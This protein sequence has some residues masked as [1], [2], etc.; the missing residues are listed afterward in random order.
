MLVAL[1]VF[2]LLLVSIPTLLC[3]SG[4]V[5]PH[6][7]GFF[8]DDNTI[9]YPRVSNYAIEDSALI[10]MDFLICIF[11][12]SLGEMIRVRSLQLSSPALLNS[13]YMVMVYKH[14]GTFIFGGMAS[15][16]LA[17]IAKMTT[18]SLRPHFL[19]VCQPDPTS[20]KCDSGYITN[21]TCTGQPA[22]ILNARQVGGWGASLPHPSHR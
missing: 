3:E 2:C 7:Q 19:A 14:L 8:C 4:Y 6:F 22:D 12:I 17:N 13:T 5:A 18:G 10:T 20:F 21:Y 15:Y 9:Q 16:S 1:D 11:M